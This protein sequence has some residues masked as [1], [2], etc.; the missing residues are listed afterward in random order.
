MPHGAIQ[1][2]SSGVVQVQINL[3]HDLNH[4][5]N[6]D[7]QGFEV[8]AGDGQGHQVA[9]TFG[10]SVADGTASITGVPLFAGQ[11]NPAPGMHQ[12]A[13][14]VD[15]A[16]VIGGS[17]LLSIDGHAQHNAFIG[18]D[19]D[20]D[21]LLDQFQEST[22]W[23]TLEALIDPQTGKGSWSFQEGP[24]YDPQ[25]PPQIQLGFEDHDGSQGGFIPLDVAGSNLASSAS[26]AGNPAPPPA[27]PVPGS[28]MHDEPVSGDDLYAA[29]MAFQSGTTSAE[30][31]EKEASSDPNQTIP[32]ELDQVP[33][34]ITADIFIG[35]EDAADSYSKTSS[36]LEPNPN[37]QTSDDN[38]P[39]P[40][41]RLD[42]SSSD[43]PFQA[44]SEPQDSLSTMI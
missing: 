31:E 27:P 8:Q 29:V 22:P 4:Q 40:Q 34:D 2:H 5:G 7:L 36:Q 14:E 39:Q 21:G 19:S 41:D 11:A 35:E 13:F 37:T 17:L 1:A 32:R 18:T 23:G 42:T 16:D 3:L 9:T 6:L 30:N 12:G 28:V 44:L 20:G 26:T 24:A 33:V 25:H 43:D 15:G 10:F 38:L